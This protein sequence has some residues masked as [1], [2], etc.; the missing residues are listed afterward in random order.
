M[1]IL[2]SAVLDPTVRVA[3]IDKQATEVPI[4]FLY[5]LCMLEVL[6]SLLIK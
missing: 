6:V 1:S 2:A 4:I 3:N 5:F